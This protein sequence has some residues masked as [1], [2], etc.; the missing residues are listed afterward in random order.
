MNIKETS[1]IKYVGKVVI[2]TLLIVFVLRCFFFESYSISTSQMESALEK[3]DEVLVSKISYGPRLP[4]TLLSLPFAF[5]KFYSSIIQLPYKRLYSSSVRY[6]DVVVFNSPLEKDKPIDKRSLLIS[7]CVAVPN[8]TIQITDG[9][10]Y[11]NGKQYPKSPTQIDEYSVVKE[12]LD[13]LLSVA[14]TLDVKIQQTS[15]ESRDSVY[16]TLDRYDAYILDKNTEEGVFYRRNY[17]IPKT[18]VFIAPSKGRQAILSENNIK[19]YRQ[20]IESEQGN[21]VR[22]ESD[23]VYIRGKKAETY[24]F[25]DDYYWML[26]DN[27]V[28]ALDSRVLGFIPFRNIVGRASLILYSSGEDGFRGDRFLT[29]VQ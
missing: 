16:F 27:T 7:R 12:D 9:N 2:I 18:L 11:I 3:G 23:G 21:N 15:R 20:I 6:N 22:F 26:S 1:I 17:V 4:I 24:T 28:D 8:D 25:Q 14:Q 19:L 29:D 10:Y 5:D 13:Y